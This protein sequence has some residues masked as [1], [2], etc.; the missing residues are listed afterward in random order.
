MSRSLRSKKPAGKQL[1]KPPPSWF[2]VQPSSS[3]EDS[4]AN[5]ESFDY[6]KDF[7]HPDYLCDLYPA[8]YRTKLM[9]RTLMKI[10]MK[11]DMR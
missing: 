10:L 11:T 7:K 2:V 8:G 3:E 6:W 4:M 9:L 5:P 1:F